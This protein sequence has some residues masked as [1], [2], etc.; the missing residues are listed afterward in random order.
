M[1]SD[2]KKSNPNQGEGNREAA[3]DYNERQREFIKS[4]KVKDAAQK[5][6]AAVDNDKNKDLKKA[7]NKGKRPAGGR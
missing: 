6:K 2:S 3:K 5:A 4:G 7:E 1:A